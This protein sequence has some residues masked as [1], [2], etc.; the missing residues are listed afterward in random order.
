[1]FTE[2]VAG[3]QRFFVDS[4]HLLSIQISIFVENYQFNLFSIKQGKK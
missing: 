2:S 3:K 4:P 1:M